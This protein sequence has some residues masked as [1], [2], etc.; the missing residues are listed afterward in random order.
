[1][2]VNNYELESKIRNTSLVKVFDGLG[3]SVS[4]GRSN[5]IVIQSYLE[6]RM[7]RINPFQLSVTLR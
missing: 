4:I 3:G 2:Y 5:C 1:M 6:Q 7:L